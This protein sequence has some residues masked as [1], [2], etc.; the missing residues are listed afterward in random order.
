MKQVFTIVK[1]SQDK[2]VEMLKTPYDAALSRT[3]KLS[4][5]IKGVIERAITR[6]HKVNIRVK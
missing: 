4:A 5:H 3:G 1:D 2:I 6:E